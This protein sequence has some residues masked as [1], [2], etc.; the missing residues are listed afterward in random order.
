MTPDRIR[1]HVVVLAALTI[2]FSAMGLIGAMVTF[3]SIAGGGLISGEMEA[4]IITSTVGSIIGGF[5]AFTSLPGLIGGVA[6]LGH[7]VWARYLVLVLSFLNLLA[8]PFGTAL[9]IYGIWLLM[10]SEVGHFFAE[11]AAAR[12][13]LRGAP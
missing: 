4:I 10:K 5:L 11:A 9:G 2:A 7:R 1:S 8:I 12:A 3:I 13:S 6:L